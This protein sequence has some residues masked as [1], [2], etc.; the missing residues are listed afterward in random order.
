MSEGRH[1]DRDGVD[2]VEEL[3]VVGEPAGSARFGH[4]AAPFGT[5]VGDGNQLGRGKLGVDAGV[6]PPERPR[7]HDA[8][9]EPAHAALRWN[10][11]VGGVTWL[12]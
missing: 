8:H 1:D 12:R 5:G 11:S 9:P 2:L 4:G 6:M 7:T 10:D 3:A